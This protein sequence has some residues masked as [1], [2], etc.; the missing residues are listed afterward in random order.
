[1]GLQARTQPPTHVQAHRSLCCGPRGPRDRAWPMVVCS[2]PILQ[3]RKLTLRE[4]GWWV[5][6]LTPTGVFLPG[7]LQSSGWPQLTPLG[8]AG[9]ALPTGS[10]F[11]SRQMTVS[12]LHCPPR[13]VAGGSEHCAREHAGTSHGAGMSFTLGGARV[14]T[15]LELPPL[16]TGLSHQGVVGSAVRGQRA[17]AGDPVHA[18]LPA[19][20]HQ[21][22]LL[23]VPAWPLGCGQGPGPHTLLPDVLA[24]GRSCLSRWLPPG[25]TVV[26]RHA[27]RK[28]REGPHLCEAPTVC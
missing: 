4:S 10:L 3:V 25:P 11:L 15:I 26:D 7:S 17:L 20:L 5:V 23:Q 1:M 18:G 12:V 13:G 14:P 8:E 19:A 22:H 21:P 27:G 6:K 24:G 16:S 2:P 28:Q 9:P